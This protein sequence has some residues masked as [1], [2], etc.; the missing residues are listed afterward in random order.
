[1]ARVVDAATSAKLKVRFAP[2]FLSFIPAVWGDYW[3][4]GLAPDYS[5]ATVGSPDR[6]YLWILS[7]SSSIGTEGY[8]AAVE[9]AKSNG[10]DVARLIRTEQTGAAK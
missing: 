4:V 8:A 9:A 2:A 5:W 3:V 7:R 10:F 1:V 6:K